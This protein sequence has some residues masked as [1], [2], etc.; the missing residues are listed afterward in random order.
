MQITK[1]LNKISSLIENY[2][3]ST[4]LTNNPPKDLP[5]LS[6]EGSQ[7][8]EVLIKYVEYYLQHSVKTY[9]P[10]FA[11]RMWS[12]S[13]A[14]AIIGELI[15]AITNTS[16]CTSESAPVSVQMEKFMLTKML[17]IVGF[18]GGE[19]QMTTGSSNGNMIAM[20]VARNKFIDNCKN[21]GLFGSGKLV[22]FVNADAH[23]SFD[24]AANILGVGVDNLIKVPTNSLG[25]MSETHLEELILKH[26]SL[27][28]TPFFVAATLGTTVRGAYDN[29]EKLTNLRDKYGFFLHGDGAWGGSVIMSETLKNKF[30]KGI[31]KLDS[32]TMDFHKMLGTSLICNFLLLNNSNKEL[33]KTCA[34]GDVSYIFRDDSDL[35]IKSLQCGRR[36]DSLKWFLDWQYFGKDGFGKRVE[37]YYNLISYAESLAKNSD[38]LEIISPQYSFNLCFRFK[39]DDAITQKVRDKLL[40]NGDGILSLAYVDN[41]LVFRLLVANVNTNEKTLDDLFKLILK[42]GETY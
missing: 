41:K 7:N 38:K 40:E 34:L 13:N 29:I 11:N 1:T 18:I 12:G 2:Q 30:V 39:G 31:E 25:E 42:T 9:Q 8:E 15:T 10:N 21:S 32:F 22:A 17:E 28:N 6:E 23:Y 26:Q 24:K 36:V 19:G 14:P 3:N 37:N 27:G 5:F 16:A 35:G 33:T 20:M 4:N